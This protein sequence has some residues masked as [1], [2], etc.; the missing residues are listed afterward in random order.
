[1]EMQRRRAKAKD[2]DGTKASEAKSQSDG[3]ESLQLVPV[4]PN[5]GEVVGN[6]DSQGSGDAKK[7]DSVAIQQYVTPQHP[8]GPPVEYGPKNLEPLF[9]EQQLQEVQDLRAKAP[10]LDPPSLCSGVEVAITPA[11]R[12]AVNQGPSSPGVPMAAGCGVGFATGMDPRIIEEERMRLRFILD[13]E[14]GM[15]QNLMRQVQ[16]EN[17][18]LRVQL[19]EEREGKY[20]TPP[21]KPIEENQRPKEFA[22][23]RRSERQGGKKEDEGQGSRKD[24]GQG[25]RKDE[26][27]GSRKE[28]GHQAQEGVHQQNWHGQQGETA[29]QADGSEESSEDQKSEEE[30]SEESEAEDEEKRHQGG[31]AES[32]RDKT[33]E[34]MLKLM[35]GMQKMQ[36][37][38]MSQQSRKAKK[39][40]DEDYREDEHIRA[41]V[42]I[43]KLPEWN[44]DSAPVDFQDWMMVI[45]PQLCDM[46]ESSAEWWTQMTAAA[47][48]WYQCHQ[49]MKPL[50][51]LQHEVKMPQ[52]LLKKKW[53]RLEKRVSNMLLQSIPESQKEEVISTKNLSVLGILTRLMINYQPGGSHEKAAVLAALESPPEATTVGEAISGPSH[54]HQCQHARSYSHV[55]RI[56]PFGQQSPCQPSQPPI[57]SE[58]HSNSPHGR[59]C[60]NYEGH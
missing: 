9:S 41:N 14:R 53:A 59:C 32:G 39:G 46:S 30:F 19:M 47:R 48:D 20:S 33:V 36:K 40:R 8:Q 50:E 44:I 58:P 54:R 35:Q 26:G 60:S 38:L 55:T 3:K 28:E 37:Q 2:N 22:S 7:E 29:D 1:M 52:E 21:D 27:Q 5:G 42:E 17:M 31:S 24:E 10:M 43:H 57:P 16:E 12:P 6:G 4:T 13:H 45:H 18:R 11:M 49:S 56:G 25:S 15:M 23:H 34:V 51:K